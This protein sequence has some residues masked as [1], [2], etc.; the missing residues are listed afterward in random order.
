MITTK[1]IVTIVFQESG[2]SRTAHTFD[3]GDGEEKTHVVNKILSLFAKAG[4]N[5]KIKK[6]LVDLLGLE[7]EK[8]KVEEFVNSPTWHRIKWTSSLGTIWVGM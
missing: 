4:R 7:N 5:V 2:N 1:N 6:Q 8:C 3:C